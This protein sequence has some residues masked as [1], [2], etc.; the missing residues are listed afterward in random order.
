[1]T[2][3]QDTSTERDLVD[4]LREHSDERLY[5]EADLLMC[6]AADEIERLRGAL[7]SRD[8]TPKDHEIARAVN[9]LRD[10]AIEFHGAQQLRER[11]AR[12]VVPLLKRASRDEAAQQP[13]GQAVSDE[14]IVAMA[15]RMCWKYRHSTDPHH[16]D[17]YKFNTALLL[18]FARAILAL[19]AKEKP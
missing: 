18:R 19:R 4:Q 2:T 16:S 3:H 13:Q 9:T 5:L 1:M 12:V 14:Q 11:I 6:E 8:E 17:T 10:I 7:A 15:F